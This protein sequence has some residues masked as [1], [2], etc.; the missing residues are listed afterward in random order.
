MYQVQM[1]KPDVKDDFSLDLDFDE[2]DIF[3]LKLGVIGV[4]SFLDKTPNLL[5]LQVSSRGLG[6]L[7]KSF[8]ANFLKLFSSN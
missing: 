1:K 3:F 6:Q 8:D 2:E 4:I 7:L 5:N